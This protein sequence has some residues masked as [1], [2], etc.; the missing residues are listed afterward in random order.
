MNSRE[1]SSSIFCAKRE[2]AVCKTSRKI[3]NRVEGGSKQLWTPVVFVFHSVGKCG[4]RKPGQRTRVQKMSEL[5][6]RDVEGDESTRAGIQEQDADLSFAKKSTTS[7]DFDRLGKIHA[8][9]T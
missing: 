2:G 5:R 3:C 1:T 4:K 8:F 6:Y 7:S 9:V